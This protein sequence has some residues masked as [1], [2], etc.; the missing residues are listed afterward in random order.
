MATSSAA[1]PPALNGAGIAPLAALMAEPARAAM[2]E[3]LLIG[4]P[5]ASGELGQIAGVSPPTASAH[6][7]RL[8]DGGLVSVTQQGRHRY[9]RL[10]GHEVATVLEV[11]SSICPPGPGQNLLRPPRR[12]G[13]GGAV[14]RAD[15]RRDADRE[16]HWHVRQLRGHRRRRG[17]AR[18]VWRGRGRGAAVPAPLLELGWIERGPSRRAVRVTGPGRDGLAATFGWAPAD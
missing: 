11:L 7:G 5:L 14:R 9:Y 18:R 8:L 12:A 4:P 16:R 2:L 13:R 10:A 3:A 6:L 1:R 17:R 15:R